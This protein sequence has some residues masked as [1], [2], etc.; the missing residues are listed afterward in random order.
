MATNRGMFSSPEAQAFLEGLW[1][2]HPIFVMVL[3][4]CS[5]LAVTTMV[6]NAIVMWLAVTATAAA[7]S[8]L[9]SLLRRQIPPGYRMMVYMLLISTLVIV[10]DRIIKVTLPAV[11]RELGPYVGLIITNCIVMGRAEAFA[12]SKPPVLSMF[13]AVGCSCGY[14]FVLIQIA[15]F[16]EIFGM[17]SF[18]GYPVMP[19][20]YV[21]CGI[22]TTAPGAFLALGLLI[23]LTRTLKDWWEGNKPS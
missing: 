8:G 16:R 23:L 17:G 12:M 15:I 6:K 5:A 10:V 19:A 21:P 2:N 13:D 14:G 20:G 22:L 7:A 1:R 9:V 3:G 4:I 11:S 18:L